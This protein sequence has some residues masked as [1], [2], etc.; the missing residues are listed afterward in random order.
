MLQLFSSIFEHAAVVAGL[1]ICANISKDASIDDFGPR[2]LLHVC[3]AF[4]GQAL[5]DEII[6]SFSTGWL[7]FTT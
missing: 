6:W 4:S 5:T 1:A 3:L 2:W 7:H